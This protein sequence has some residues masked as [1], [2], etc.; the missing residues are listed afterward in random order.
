MRSH[1]H[2]S[3]DVFL[4]LILVFLFYTNGAIAVAAKQWE[5]R[6]IHA[7]ISSYPQYMKI[8]PTDDRITQYRQQD[9]W[10][11]KGDLFIPWFCFPFCCLSGRS[12]MYSD[13]G[14]LEIY[15]NT[16]AVDIPD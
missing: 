11:S 14:I 12:H 4:A 7:L 1:F 13:D 16:L 9:M 8:S 10:I 6:G 5:M 15:R 2:Y 3:A